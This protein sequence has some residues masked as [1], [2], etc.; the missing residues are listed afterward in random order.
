MNRPMPAPTVAM[1]LW[2]PRG[3]RPRDPREVY[4]RLLPLAG[5]EI[6]DLGCGKADVSRA[7]AT[8]IKGASVTAL[9]VDRI[10]HDL[11]CEQPALPNLKF[12]LGGA[13]KIPA[14][15]ASFDIVMMNKSLHHVPVDMMGRAL[16]EVRRVLRS[17]GLA[18]I[19]EPIFAGEFNE[20]LRIFHDERATR[21]AA[22][23]AIQEIIASGVMEL[24]TEE[25]YLAP[26]HVVDYADFE[27]RFINVT[28][29]DY[30]LSV[31]QKEQVK[32]K[33]ARAV[34]PKGA[35][36]QAPMR[37]DVLRKTGEPTRKARADT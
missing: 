32:Q 7:I 22:F 18:Y 8:S 23:E 17:G 33:L 15:D 31:S 16:R 19:L 36:F 13:E 20:I 10:Q 35:T 26:M 1:Q 30:R 28:H 2:D 14:E 12:E 37:V 9:E 6:L 24:V 5:A 11:N 4:E 34:A 29:G 3:A 25:F 27:Q 21:Q